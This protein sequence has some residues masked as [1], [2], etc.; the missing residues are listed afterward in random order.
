MKKKHMSVQYQTTV[1]WDATLM[2]LE[3]TDAS[4]IP[5]AMQGLVQSAVKITS[6]APTATAGKFIPGAIVQNAVTGVLY[7]NSGTTASPVWSVI[8]ASTGGLP[9]LT[10]AHIWVGNASN[11]ATDVAMS[12]VIAITNAGV[13]SIVD[14]SIV[15]ADINATAAIDFSKLAALT[16]GNILVGSAGNVATSVAMSGDAAISNTGVVTVTDL[17]IAG[18]AAGSI[19]YFNGTNWVPLAA[20]TAGQTLKMNGG[21]TAPE[22]VTV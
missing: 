21:A 3:Y 16:S 22:W 20:G 18:E 12:G 14:G 10:A 6:G 13:T 2:D 4:T 17:T 19:I 9:P 1:G 8:D 7:V 5:T 11:V 15:N